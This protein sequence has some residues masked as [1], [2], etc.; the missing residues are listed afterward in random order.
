MPE[1]NTISLTILVH[2]HTSLIFTEITVRAVA[3]A[4]TLPL[5]I[6]CCDNYYYSSLLLS[7]VYC[8]YCVTCKKVIGHKVQ[9]V[10]SICAVQLQSME[11]HRCGAQKAR[12]SGRFRALHL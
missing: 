11:V 10:L 2:L 5:R 4:V 7:H 9:Q 3:V 6:S 1:D 8:A 12:N